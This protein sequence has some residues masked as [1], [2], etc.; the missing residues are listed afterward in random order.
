M[1]SGL[2][3]QAALIWFSAPFLQLFCVY[4]LYR[5]KLVKQFAFFASYLLL[6][7]LLNAIR[8]FCYRE[9]GLSSWTY[10]SAYW[11]GTALS[12]LAAIAVLYE[13]FCAAFKPFTGLQD[14]SKIVFKWAAGSISFIGLVVFVGS[15]ASSVGS[16]H[17]WL[18]AS[19]H[20]FER[21]VGVMECALL[22]FLFIGSQH[23]GLSM[24]N[25]VFGLALGFGLDALCRLVIYSAM[26]SSHMSKIPLWSQLLPMGYYVSLLI[27]VG[28]L[29]KPEP[30]RE[31]LQI[32]LSSPLLR[33]NEIALQLGHSGGKVALLNPEPF[34]PQVERMVE[35]VLQKEFVER[36]QPRTRTE[37]E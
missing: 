19:V 21:V 3:L 37:I 23:L 13:I 29:L 8:F 14:L 12:N 28:Y 36:R 11:V 33:W 30:A 26:I 35:R 22:I 25:R 16:P 1:M 24:R 20:D 6:F 27:W 9:F 10:Y 31:S 18:S 7:T 4:L 34:M 17:H 15:Y 2:T 5:R 32:P